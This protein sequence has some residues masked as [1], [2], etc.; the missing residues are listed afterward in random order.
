MQAG[1]MDYITL[2]AVLKQDF[3]TTAGWSIPVYC[4]DG[5]G[6][7]PLA[8]GLRIFKIDFHP[9]KLVSWYS[10]FCAEASK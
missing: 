6:F 10:V 8:G 1:W 2:V 7:K 9:Q 3:H 5:P 4:T